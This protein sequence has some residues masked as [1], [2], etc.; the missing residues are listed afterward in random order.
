MIGNE[1]AEKMSQHKIIISDFVSLEVS[2]V[3]SRFCCIEKLEISLFE[4]KHSCACVSD[5]KQGHCLL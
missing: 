4:G 1:C 2:L 3:G 5:E